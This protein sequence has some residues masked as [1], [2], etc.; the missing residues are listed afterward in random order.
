MPERFVQGTNPTLCSYKFFRANYDEGG[1]RIFPATDNLQGEEQVPVQSCYF[2]A[3]SGFAGQRAQSPF[4]IT[5]LC[6]K[7]DLASSDL[8]DLYKRGLGKYSVDQFFDQH[9]YFEYWITPDVISGYRNAENLDDIVGVIKREVLDP[10]FKHYR[11]CEINIDAIQYINLLWQ[12][13][14]KSV[15]VDLIDSLERK[16]RSIQPDGICNPDYSLRLRFIICLPYEVFDEIC[17]NPDDLFP[18]VDRVIQIERRL[19]VQQEADIENYYK[20]KNA[21][22]HTEKQKGLEIPSED[23]MEMT[24]SNEAVTEKWKYNTEQEEML[25]ENRKGHLSPRW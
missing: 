16:I 9:E 15:V 23:K 4:L 22:E 6:V 24:H 13:G 14:L 10:L 21:R 20:K 8:L 25:S 12:A 2:T 17:D 3:L 19:T 7:P 11:A 18:L 1:Q 5:C